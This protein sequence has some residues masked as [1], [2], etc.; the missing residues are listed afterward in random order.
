M[1]ASKRT[2]AKLKKLHEI[3]RHAD[4]Q[5]AGEV[6]NAQ[7]LF[8]TLMAQYG[9]TLADLN[10]E[11]DVH[12]MAS[13]VWAKENT[14][15]FAVAICQALDV[16]CIMAH[17]GVKLIGLDMA[18][19][20]ACHDYLESAWLQA[21]GMLSAL[22]KVFKNASD[23]SPYFEGYSV[24]YSEAIMAKLE[25]ETDKENAQALVLVGRALSILDA[26]LADDDTVTPQGKE[27]PMS[28]TEQNMWL[29]GYQNGKQGL[30]KL[31]QK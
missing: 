4:K 3:L 26:K 2:I 7:S 20:Q 21:S 30:K 18:D 23:F 28:K 6:E 10:L 5:T 11:P 29:M 13:M 19:V 25:F 12:E 9:L 16:R 31:L 27:K 8:D 1:K 24:G 17:D 14:K 22:A 15:T